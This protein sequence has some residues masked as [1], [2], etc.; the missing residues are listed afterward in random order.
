[1]D[2]QLECIVE[3]VETRHELEALLCLGCSLVRVFLF[4]AHTAGADR[5]L[6]QP[7][8]HEGLTPPTHDTLYRDTFAQTKKNPEIL[9]FVG[10]PDFL[11]QQIWW[12]VWDSNLRPIG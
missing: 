10:V 4:E 9:T 2:M 12:V 7:Q 3:G 1:M 11:L 6:A 5:H 8:E